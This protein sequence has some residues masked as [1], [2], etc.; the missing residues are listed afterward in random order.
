MDVTRRNRRIS[1]SEEIGNG[2]DSAMD[3][4]PQLKVLYQLPDHLHMPVD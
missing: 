1:S 3:T 2:C 4:Q